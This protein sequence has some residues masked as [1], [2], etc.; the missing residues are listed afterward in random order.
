MTD[1]K[2]LIDQEW[3]HDADDEPGCCRLTVSA[4]GV[5]LAEVLNAD[6]FPCLADDGDEDDVDRKVQAVDA[7]ARTV[8]R[9]MA[10]A[11]RLLGLVRRAVAVLQRHAP[12]DGLSDRDALSELYG[13]FDGPEYRAAMAKAGLDQREAALLAESPREDERLTRDDLKRAFAAGWRAAERNSRAADDEDIADAP[14][15]AFLD[16]EKFEA[17]SPREDAPRRSQQEEQKEDTRVDAM[18]DPSDSPTAMVKGS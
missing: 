5:P 15:V 17:D 14:D 18:G 16:W 6:D 9:L 3:D 10:A 2:A 7:E 11:P 1:T 12:P 4:G 13:I 8:A